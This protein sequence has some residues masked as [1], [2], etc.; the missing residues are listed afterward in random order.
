MVSGKEVTLD[1]YATIFKDPI[2]YDEMMKSKGVLLSPANCSIVES[3]N[4]VKLDVYH[5]D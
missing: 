4:L 5:N 2:K 3:D 1:E